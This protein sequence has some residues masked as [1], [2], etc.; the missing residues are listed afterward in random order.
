MR[1]GPAA[2]LARLQHHRARRHEVGCGGGVD[3]RL[4]GRVQ[5]GDGRRLGHRLADG[6]GER[7][8][9]AV[10]QPLRPPRA[11]F[12]SQ[13]VEIDRGR[14]AVLLLGL[15]RHRQPGRRLEPEPHHRLVDRADLLDVEGAVGDALAVEQQQLV[16]RAVDG[17]V[18]DQR[19]F[20]P[21]V[22]LARPGAAAGFEKREAVGVEQD[23][24]AL[25]EPQSAYGGAVMKEPEQHQE[26]RPGAVALVHR[27]GVQRRVLAQSLVQAGERVVAREGLVIGQQVAFL[28]V[29]Q[30]DE[31]QDD[32]EQGVV[33]VVGTLGQRSAQQR[34]A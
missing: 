29:E 7:P 4:Q 2:R 28:G 23:A 16:E 10:P 14:G 11:R 22:E 24:V 5:V 33:D 1:P 17:A 27:V 34:A 8:I 13:R 19:R 25:G 21:I 18:G 3:H 6:I 30:E 9:G 32:G 26:L 15:D 20:D 31:P 12:A